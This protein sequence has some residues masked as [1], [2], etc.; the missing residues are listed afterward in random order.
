[1]QACHS[2]AELAELDRRQTASREQIVAAYERS[3]AESME[4]LADT[5]HEALARDLVGP[6][7]FATPP[8]R[9]AA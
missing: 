2:T 4:A 6:D 8:V 9:R 7:D 1:M 5:F 3:V